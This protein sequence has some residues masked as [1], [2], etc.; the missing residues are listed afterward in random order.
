MARGIQDTL[1]LF[2][3]V[4][5]LAA[6]TPGSLIGLPDQVEVE[7]FRWWTHGYAE[8]CGPFRLILA[9]PRVRLRRRREELGFR[10]IILGLQVSWMMSLELEGTVTM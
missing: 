6:R 5:E 8:R 4:D 2:W 9:P 1:T 10:H 7:V 3:Y